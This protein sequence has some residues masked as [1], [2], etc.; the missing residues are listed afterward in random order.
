MDD[1]QVEEILGY[2]KKFAWSPI[3]KRTAFG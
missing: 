2:K 1:N 3:A